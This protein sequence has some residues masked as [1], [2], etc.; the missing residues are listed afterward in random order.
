[1][2]KRV[3]LQNAFIKNSETCRTPYSFVTLVSVNYNGPEER[4][5]KKSKCE[6]EPRTVVDI[7]SCS[8]CYPSGGI[9]IKQILRGFIFS[10][11]NP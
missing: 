8:I 1:M 9:S 4:V 7:I 10:Y 11:L 5:L 2:A 3:E 6:I